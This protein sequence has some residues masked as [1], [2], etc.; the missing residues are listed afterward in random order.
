MNPLKTYLKKRTTAAFR[1]AIANVAWEYHMCLRQRSELRKV[2]RF[3]NGET[4]KLNLGCGPNRK[5]GWVNIDLFEQAADLKLDLR[6]PWPFPNA[7]VSHIYSEHVFEHLDFHEE[8]PHW[9]SEALRVLQ[10]QGV[11]DVGVPDTEWPLRAWAN[12]DDEY[13]SFARS[14]CPTWCQTRLD[15]VNY[16]FRQDKLH[17]EHKYAWD[18][19]TL[20]RTLKRAGFISV[21]RRP[22][23]PSL[24]AES[25]RPGT[26]YVRAV[27]PGG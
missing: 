7:C 16:H 3:R 1:S 22:F 9:L 14:L 24:D 10:P 2:Y 12:P 25:R 17:G 15:V 18:E 20:V 27:K 8:V 5:K 26:L 23:D 11:F 19:E 4:L 13:W 21:E 6:E